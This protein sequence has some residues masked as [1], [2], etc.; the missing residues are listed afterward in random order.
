MAA[1]SDESKLLG[2]FI[3]VHYHYQMLLETVRV[4]GFKEA[5]EKLTPLGGKVLELGSG[6][7]VLSF[8]ASKIASKVWAVE[9]SPELAAFSRSTLDRN[10][11]NN[12]TVIEG[13]A[14][15]YLPDEPVD[16]VICEML[17]SALLR[18]KQIQ[19]IE[20]FKRRYQAKFGEVLPRFI[21]EATIIG[22][23]PVSR[24]FD[25]EGYHA[26]VPMFRDPYVAD[27]ETIPLGNPVNYSL[28]E[29]KKETPTSFNVQSSL[30]CDAIGR[31]NALRFITKN[32]LGIVTE[33]N[34]AIDWHNQYLVIPLK[35]TIEVSPGTTLS[36]RFAYNV[37]GSLNE[38]MDS[39]EVYK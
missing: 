3:P 27:P 37:G 10:G 24:S 11:A 6:T 31:L 7:G 16:V 28:F 13:D 1:T 18:E 33:E 34:K 23:Q 4:K 25:F 5:I 29:Y 30:T 36:V 39:L 22:F 38:L 35:S 14:M 20:S 2:Q 12:V 32:I 19:V 15:E 26:P 8:F 17:H 21:P 9:R